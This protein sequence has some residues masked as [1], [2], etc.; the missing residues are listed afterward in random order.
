MVEFIVGNVWLV[1]L[2]VAIVCLIMEVSSGD[3]FITCFAVGALCGMAASSLGLPFWAQVLVFA[4]FSTLSIRLLRPRLLG[5]LERRADKRES[6]ADALAGRVGE[7]IQTI[8]SD[9]YGRVKIDGDD[10]KAESVDGVEIGQGERVSVVGRESI[11]LKVV[12]A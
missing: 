9:G 4:L 12:R 1:W 3:F 2:V 11:I 10:W 5:L 7:V 6:N 8:E